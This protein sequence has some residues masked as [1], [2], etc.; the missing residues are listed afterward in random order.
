[1][2]NWK[3][4]LISAATAAIG[5]AVAAL[6]GQSLTATTAI[7]AGLTFVGTFVAALMKGIQS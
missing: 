5:P 3:H 4:L 1:M 2:P 6:A 7:V